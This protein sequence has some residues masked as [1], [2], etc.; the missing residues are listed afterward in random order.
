MH[1]QLPLPLPRPLSGRDAVGWAGV[2]CKDVCNNCAIYQINTPGTTQ[3]LEGTAGREWEKGRGRGEGWGG[4]SVLRTRVKNQTEAGKK[5]ESKRE[6]EGEKK[7][8]QCNAKLEM[9]MKMEKFIYMR[10]DGNAM[11]GHNN[12]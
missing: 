11:V 1:S 5:Q 4:C 6:S 7:G 10:F 2:N 3:A 9:E 8:K 12:K